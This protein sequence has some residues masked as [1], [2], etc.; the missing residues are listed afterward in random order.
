MTLPATARQ[1]PPTPS[2][3]QLLGLD[4]R[5][6]LAAT[7]LP[8]LKVPLHPAA[9][10]ALL[11]LHAVAAAAGFDLQALSGHRS[12]A[13]QLAIIDDKARGRRPL[14]AADEQPLDATAMP[15][16]QRLRALLHWSALPGASRHHWGSE[17]DV[18]DAAVPPQEGCDT[19]TLAEAQG[20]SAALHAWLDTRIATG[21]AEGF[22]RPY[23][24]T[25]A[26]VDGIGS[27]PW[28]L[29]Y[30]P[31]SSQ[32]AATLADTNGKQLL[33]LLRGTDF[34]LRDTLLANWTQIYQDFVLPHWCP[35]SQQL[36]G[37]SD[38]P[39]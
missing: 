24:T 39:L 32:C 4:D 20:P 7:A 19:L 9:G 37:R 6:V 31:L 1:L 13:R 12:F 16:L 35:P 29:S 36:S 2:L 10:R 14:L 23:A 26:A 22:V 8:G 34:A 28:H 30:A 18:C 15:P 38:M 21:C 27:E 33:D 5:H 17:V 25:S 3:K 11:R